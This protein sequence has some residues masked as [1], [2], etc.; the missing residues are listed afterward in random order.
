M[1]QSCGASVAVKGWYSATKE[2]CGGAV[3]HLLLVSPL[4][5]S[6]SRWHRLDRQPHLA[7]ASL[8]ACC[9]TVKLC[10]LRALLENAFDGRLS[11]V[12]SRDRGLERSGP[13]RAREALVAS[14]G[15]LR[16]W[17]ARERKDRRA[18]QGASAYLNS[19]PP[20]FA[21]SHS[22]RRQAASPGRF[23]G[24]PTTVQRRPPRRVIGAATRPESGPGS[25]RSRSL[26]PWITTP[27]RLVL[28]VCLSQLF[29]PLSLCRPSS[30]RFAAFRIAWL[31][32]EKRGS[33]AFVADKHVPVRTYQRTCGDRGT[34]TPRRRPGQRHPTFSSARTLT[35]W[36]CALTH[37]P[38]R[39]PRRGHA[40]PHNRAW[41]ARERFPVRCLFVPSPPF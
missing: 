3:P 34:S 35:L 29:H 41:R 37:S 22:A 39:L 13:L 8:Q 12:R 18:A 5:A 28:A 23:R 20:A 33:E 26:C 2:S 21:P 31:C 10:G 36:T 14:C 15:T 30:R 9:A 11:S 4:T 24:L 6:E 19:W 32:A 38:G 27:S 7:R 40:Q 17:P 1:G 25:V 16:Q